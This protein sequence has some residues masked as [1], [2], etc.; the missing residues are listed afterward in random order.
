MEANMT[1]V[2]E[3]TKDR[4]WEEMFDI[5]RYI[6]YYEMKTNRLSFWNK[7]IRLLLLVGA[8]SAV[9]AV[10]D[11]LPEYFGIG[12]ALAL[13]V[14]T[15]IDLIWD[16]GTKAALSHAINLEC[17]V[18]EKDYEDLWLL[19]RTDR[20]DEIESQDRVNRLAMRVIA[21][22]A[23]LSETDKRLNKKASDAAAIILA[24]RWGGTIGNSARPTT[25]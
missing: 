1:P 18:I 14:L 8:T 15:A 11:V 21:A 13:L 4:I 2:T 3:R 19:V 16:W 12:G 23:Q 22:T 25:A 10:F 24:D 5:A 17:C 20:S 9:G 7:V 6:Q